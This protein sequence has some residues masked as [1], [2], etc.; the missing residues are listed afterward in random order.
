MGHFVKYGSGCRTQSTGISFQSSEVRVSPQAWELA[1]HTVEEDPVEQ[2][3]ST[4][5]QQGDGPK[6]N[7]FFLILI[8]RR[9]SVVCL[10]GWGQ[11]SKVWIFGTVM[12]SW[13]LAYTFW[14]LV[15]LVVLGF[16]GTTVISSPKRNLSQYPRIFP[17]FVPCSPLWNQRTNSGQPLPGLMT[18]TEISTWFV[19]A[20]PWKFM[21]L[22]FLS[23]RGPLLNPLCLSS[24]DW[25]G[26]SLEHLISKKYFIFNP[27][28][29]LGFYI[30]HIFL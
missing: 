11:A 26:A 18:S 21:N 12:K 23:R 2:M 25:F 14:V 28:L 17:S 24:S 5:I 8:W 27:R 7:L 29:K 15:G 3:F 19:P 4:I 1:G 9:Y 22:H 10:M 6:C 20:P 30:L 16:D 13:L